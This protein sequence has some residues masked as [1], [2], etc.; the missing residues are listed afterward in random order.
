MSDVSN[1]GGLVQLLSQ[2]FSWCLPLELRHGV[3]TTG[4]ALGIASSR[5][6][7]LFL[8]VSRWQCLGHVEQLLLY[9]ELV[10]DEEAHHLLK[11]LVGWRACG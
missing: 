9:F 7:T 2:H 6:L 3:R 5:F 8:C 10:L 4:R 11:S 1:V